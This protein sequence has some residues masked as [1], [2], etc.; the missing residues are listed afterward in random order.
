MRRRISISGCVRLSVRGSVSIKENAV[1]RVLG[2]SYVGY[3]ALLL[4]IITCVGEFVPFRVETQ[5]EHDS[6]GT[7]SDQL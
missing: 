1:N 4:S 3:P 5:V 2:S 6:N 7:H